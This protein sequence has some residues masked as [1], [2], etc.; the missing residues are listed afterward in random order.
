MIGIIIVVCCIWI[1]IKN[2]KKTKLEIDVDISKINK[3]CELTKYSIP[4]ITTYDHSHLERIKLH[5]KNLKLEN[6]MQELDKS[7]R[8]DKSFVINMIMLNTVQNQKSIDSIIQLNKGIVSVPIKSN[9]L[10]NMA[11]FETSTI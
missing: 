11:N 10:I 6:I 4:T 2:F 5:L 7:S 1:I 8:N 9:H 3:F